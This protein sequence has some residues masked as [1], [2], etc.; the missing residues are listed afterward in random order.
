MVLLMLG[1]GLMDAVG[2]ATL[3]PVLESGLGASASNDTA[4]GRAMSALP[5]ALELEPGLGVLLCIMVVAITLKAGLRSLGMR[6]VART[7]ARLA[8]DLRMGLIRALVAARWSYFVHEPIGRIANAV[9]TEAQRAAWAYRRACAALAHGLQIAVYTLVLVLISW[10]VAAVAVLLGALTTV[11]LGRFIRGSRRAG[12]DETAGIQVL[13]S[14]LADVIHG[15]RPIKAMG[16]ELQFLRIFESDAKRLEHAE[17]R[18]AVF[19][20]SLAALQEPVVM[21]II[22]VGLYASVTWAGQPLPVSLLVMFVF[23]RIVTRFHA[24][25]SEYQAMVAVESAFWSLHQQTERANAEHERLPGAMATPTLTRSLELRDVSFSYG[26]RPILRHLTLRIPAG[27]FVAITGPSGAGKTTMADLI[28]ALQAPDSGEIFVDDTPLDEID[29]A[30]WRKGIGYVPQDTLLLHDSV[31]NNVNLGLETVDRRD[32]ERALRDAGAWPFV[33]ALPQGIDTVIGERGTRLSGGER[34]RIA[35][36]RALASQPR[37]LV[38]DEATAGLDPATEHAIC[39][40]LRS[41]REKVTILAISHQ[42]RIAAVADVAYEL[43]DG[44]LRTAH[45]AVAV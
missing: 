29:V 27:S 13:V 18:Q 40:T 14:R 2:V 21:A 42:S 38:L 45:E 41:L 33:C 34:Q 10:R 20:D 43:R 8:S 31:A 19:G 5:R 26:Q 30:A 39:Q 6:H 25:Q 12:A 24:M 28:L 11:L 44:A 35:I 1:A 16:R 4:L 32:I 37:L 23:Y 36:A 17:R 22:A 15:I 7:V 9:G 3:L